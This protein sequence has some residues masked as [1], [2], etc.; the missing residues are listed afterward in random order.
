MNKEQ[1]EALLAAMLLAI[2]HL[3]E[4]GAI[5]INTSW[6]FPGSRKEEEKYDVKNP[7]I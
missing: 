7:A 4:E 6:F 5:S 1:E 2:E 3:V